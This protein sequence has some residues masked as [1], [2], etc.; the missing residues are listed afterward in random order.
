MKSML[1][2]VLLV[3]GFSLSSLKA[4]P[5]IPF[6]P[7]EFLLKHHLLSLWLYHCILLVAFP[8]LILIF[9]LC[10][11]SLLLW[12]ICVLGVFCFE[13]ILLS[14]LGFL[15]IGGYLFPHF[16]NFWLL[17]TQVFSHA[18]SF[19]TP[20]IQ[21]LGHLTLSQ[22]FLRL[23]SFIFFLFSFFFLSASF[24]SII[25][26]ST[27]LIHSCASVILLL[28]PSR[29]LLISVIAFLIDSSLFHQGPCW[30][31]SVLVSSLF[32]CKSIW[33]SRFLIIFIIIILNSFSG[34]LPISS[35]FVLFGGFLSCSFTCW[36]FLCLFILFR[37]LCLAAFSAGWKF[38]VPLDCG[39]YSMWVGLDYWLVQVYWLGEPVSMP[40]WMELDLV[41]LKCNEVSSSEFLGVFGFDM[42]LGTLSFNAQGHVPVFLE[43]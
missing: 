30:I 43:N 24:I 4:Y 28:V 38:V 25:L 34:R 23:S 20:I 33:F 11:L 39:I 1:C 42:D 17:S 15:D 14:T 41:S 6:W 5:T 2:G 32:I 13:L 35:F 40:W 36:I 37:L 26:S 8:V 12:L 29:V 9:A 16:K 31:F 18:L 19:G 7:E 27:S 21:M 3:V 22:R 10:V